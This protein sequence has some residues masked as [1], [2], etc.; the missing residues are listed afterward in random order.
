MNSKDFVTDEEIEAAIKIVGVNTTTEEGRLVLA[1]GLLKAAAGYRSSC[2]EELFMGKF[3][4]LR[5]DRTLNRKGAMF[6]CS[7]FY[8]CSNRRPESYRLMQVYRSP[9]E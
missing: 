3:H 4:L 9:E 6:L 2:T 8:S 7:M 1:E 5:V